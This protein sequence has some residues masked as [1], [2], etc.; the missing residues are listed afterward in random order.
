MVAGDRY[1]H[2]LRD[3]RDLQRTI[4]KHDSI[5]LNGL[6]AIF[7]GKL[8]CGKVAAIGEELRVILADID[9]SIRVII[10]ID[11]LDI[12][13]DGIA[14]DQAGNGILLPA[15][16]GDGLLT[17]VIDLR[18]GVGRDGQRNLIVD[19]NNVCARVRRDGDGISLG[20]I[21][22]NG[23]QLIIIIKRAIV[24]RLR[25]GGELMADGHGAGLIV[26]DLDFGAFQ[27]VMDGIGG[28][29]QL[30]DGVK[31]V[32]AVLIH[33]SLHAGF[34]AG[35]LPILLGIPADEAIVRGRGKASAG[36]IKNRHNAVDKQLINRGLAAITGGPVRVV[37]QGDRILRGN[38]VRGQ[39]GI[40][41]HGDILAG[42]IH[43]ALTIRPV[44]EDQL[45][46]LL[47][48]RGIGHAGQGI[49]AVFV[50][51]RGRDSG[52]PLGQI[53]LQGIGGAGE[54]GPDG[55][56][57][58]QR[59][60][61]IHGDAVAIHPL[62]EG[63]V[64]VRNVFLRFL[65]GLGLRDGGS[66]LQIFTGV[67]LVACRHFDGN[68]HLNGGIPP[69]GIEHQVLGGHGFIGEIK[70]FRIVRVSGSIFDRAGLYFKPANKLR[71][72][73]A[74]RTSRHGAIPGNILFKRDRLRGFSAIVIQRKLKAV[75][76]IIEI[77]NI[78][79]IR[80]TIIKLRNSVIP[81][82]KAGDGE[83]VFLVGK[84]Y[85]IPFNR[86]RVIQIVMLV[87][88]ASGSIA[89]IILARKL[90]Q[91]II[92]SVLV[93]R[94]FFLR[95]RNVLARHLL[96]E[97]VILSGDAGPKHSTLIKQALDGLVN[98][99]IGNIGVI[100]CFYRR[101]SIPPIYK[102]QR[103]LFPRE[104]HIQHGGAVRGD[105]DGF[106]LRRIKGEM[107]SIRRSSGKGLFIAGLQHGSGG[108]LAV[109][110]RQNG[111]VC[112]VGVLAPIDDG[113]RHILRRPMRLQHHAGGGGVSGTGDLL[114]AQIPAG[115]RVTQLGGIGN[116][117]HID[118][119]AISDVL[120]G[121]AA[122]AVGIKGDPVGG[123]SDG[124]DIGIRLH[125]GTGVECLIR[126]VN[127]PAGKDSVLHDKFRRGGGNDFIIIVTG[128]FT[129]GKDAA[130]GGSV[131]FLKEE[132]DVVNVGEIRVDLHG[133]L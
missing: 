81:L 111:I 121:H 26:S 106:V 124:R 9:L 35:A 51:I 85:A 53:I 41:V 132:I 69:I 76:Q 114:L 52:S 67:N 94:P 44:A 7:N 133:S 97:R 128:R 1:R 57:R 88:D 125:D 99:H 48:G 37:G 28:L 126:S 2:F 23:S 60:V 108:L 64:V 43:V 65:I 31:N 107:L 120:G 102:R 4:S 24:L 19:G 42:V 73:I 93:A 36:Q 130:R 6:I 96:K 77:C 68:I 110:D 29:I 17:A 3:R 80:I 8:V 74:R 112:I 12:G 118:A 56:I 59:L 58:I 25:R 123:H 30:P 91:I 66:G 129:G 62:D 75:A 105:G 45:A 22:G 54:N 13:R 5:I 103:I 27:I 117:G 100:F 61:D 46:A 119:L 83:I 86:S 55:L 101:N 113:V 63:Q 79:S 38:I 40:G 33:A 104:I 131:R 16:I 98:P 72:L 15:L 116:L 127:H 82:L 115:E 50:A 122:A 34:K 21:A 14:I 71:V 70:G 95:H 78:C 39:G 84:A 32:F 47:G 10:A 90:L 20:R 89:G 49:G 18:F 109:L 92:P 11:D 87:A